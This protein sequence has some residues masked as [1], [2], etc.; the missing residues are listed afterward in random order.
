MKVVNNAKINSDL[1]VGDLLELKSDFGLVEHRLVFKGKEGY[2]AVNTVTHSVGL[3]SDTLENMLSDYKNFYNVVTII[4]SERL[5]L[6][7]E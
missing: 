5:T 4:K 1:E 7:V 3:I 6:T 2:Y